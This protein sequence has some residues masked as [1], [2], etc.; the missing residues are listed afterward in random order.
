MDSNGSIL[1]PRV[2]WQDLDQMIQGT[3]LGFV[4]I[5]LDPL[6]CLKHSDL[7]SW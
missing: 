5:Q 1:S 6:L 4:R 3:T 2:K 7:K